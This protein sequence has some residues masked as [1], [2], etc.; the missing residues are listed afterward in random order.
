MDFR[1]KSMT[2]CAIVAGTM[3]GGGIDGRGIDASVMDAGGM[4]AGGMADTEATGATLEL[5]WW[6]MMSYNV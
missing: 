3:D 1:A 4:D 6:G 2:I 5:S